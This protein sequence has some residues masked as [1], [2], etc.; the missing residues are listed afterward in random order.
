VTGP[1]VPPD[2]G[3]P[4]NGSH[5]SGHFVGAA[6]PARRVVP[7]ATNAPGGLIGGR[8][9]ADDWLNQA[10]A[11]SREPRQPETPSAPRDRSTTQ[12]DV[13]EDARAYTRAKAVAE[14]QA[15]ALAQARE[16]AAET[17]AP[18]A[19][20]KAKVLAAATPQA[21]PRR[22]ELRPRERR[23]RFRHFGIH[24]GQVMTWEGA[25]FGLLA[26]HRQPL[27]ILIPVAAVA[28]A[29][30]VLTV[31]KVEGRWLYEWLGL[32][33]RY[34]ARRRSYAAAPNDADALLASIARGAVVENVDVDDEPMAIISHAGGF[35]AILEPA[36][37]SAFL[38]SQPIAGSSP[39]PPIAE[40]LSTD[41]GPPVAVQLVVQT[42]PA[43]GLA[44]EQ[45][46]AAQSYAEL[47]SG[48]LPAQRRVWIAVQ[49]QHTADSFTA[50]QL[51]GALV[52]AVRRL[53]RK[54]RKAK[55]SVNILSREETVTEFLAMLNPATGA[56]DAPQLA[57]SEGWR[58]WRSG[59]GVHTS[60]RLR[61]WPNLADETGARLL[62]RLSA[63]PT[64]ATAIG[65]AARR[66]DSEYELEAT[67]RVL[68][69]D[70]SAARRVSD[71]LLKVSADHGV[72]LQR[73]DGE[74]VFGVGAS[75]PLG[76]FA[77]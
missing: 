16:R 5:Q 58:V 12:F 38:D 73:L 74:Q 71:Q 37:D 29:A 42:T 59:S 72:R 11:T 52:N 47:N 21:P 24:V 36:Q 20:A 64:L 39:L 70:Q 45:D 43:P 40:L 44:G 31:V 10:A 13:V 33:V 77:A 63:V 68:V 4:A 8:R 54:L 69:T 35:T 65:I 75:V 62:E 1:L 7:P 60:F 34:H 22:D 48:L 56:I 3:E 30:I 51:R 55:F 6:A 2:G 17:S 9:D 25:A 32:R 61:G 67:V 23:D 26:V 28:L 57:V 66:S 15:R 49:A 18:P 53:R 41:D 76:G 14:Q 46:A 19:A 27:P 50:A